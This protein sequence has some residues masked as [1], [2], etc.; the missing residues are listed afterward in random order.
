MITDTQAIILSAAAQ[1]A[2]GNVLPLPGSLRGGAAKKVVDALLAR[3]WIRE[4]DTDSPR[5]ADPAL[6]TIWR[7][8]EDGR[9]V[10]LFVTQAGLD[11]IGVEADTAAPSPDEAASA[12]A[13]DGDARSADSADTRALPR[14]G[15]KLALL[16]DLLR[17]STGV[18]LAEISAATGWQQHTVRGAM[19]GALGRKLGLKVV[20]EKAKG[21]DRRYRLPS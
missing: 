17:R 12:P 3:G 14:P 15:T 4:H 5:R 2:D 11:A 7:N 21:E 8:R 20:S 1:R 18:T 10:L 9:G 16:V 19:A 13:G 6:N